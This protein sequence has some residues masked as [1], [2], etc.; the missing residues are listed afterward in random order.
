MGGPHLVAHGMRI[1]ARDDVHPER[2]AALDERA[3]RIALPQPRAAMVQGH[4]GRVVR[5]DAAG[6]QARGVCADAVEVVE[7]ELRVE[8]ARI[9]LDEREL[10]PAHRPIE[11]AGQHVARPR[12][13]GR[14]LRRIQRRMKRSET[15]RAA[16]DFQ[17]LP[18]GEIGCHRHVLFFVLPWAAALAAFSRILNFT[19]FRS[20]PTGMGLSSGN[21]TVPLPEA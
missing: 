21:L 18:P 17:K 11:P 5:D 1:G 19:I 8:A 16:G 4:L 2:A 10:D 15:S 7:P 6:A 14:A 3:E 20:T 9:V 12:R 13:C